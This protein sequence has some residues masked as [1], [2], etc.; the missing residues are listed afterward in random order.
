MRLELRLFVFLGLALVCAQA[1][2]TASNFVW[3]GCGVDHVEVKS[4]YSE[5]PAAL[6]DLAGAALVNY[7]QE[8]ECRLSSGDVVR[9]KFGFDFRALSSS[10]TSWVSIWFN[11]KKWVS[12]RN[13]EVEG[14]NEPRA[15][16]IEVSAE[17]VKLC[18]LQGSIL[19]LDDD[20]DAGNAAPKCTQIPRSHLPH[21]VDVHEPKQLDESEKPLVPPVILAGE[22]HALCRIMARTDPAVREHGISPASH[23]WLN[24]PTGNP[25]RIDHPSALKAKAWME[26]DVA[27]D[28][29]NSGL[30]RHVLYRSQSM[31]YGEDYDIYLTL[32]DADYQRLSKQAV[33]EKALLKIARSAWPVDWLG[34]QD[35]VKAS[36]QLDKLD[37]KLP[38]ADQPES[39]V[40]I[41][42]NHLHIV[43]FA[44]ASRTY[45]LLFDALAG[46][47]AFVVEPHPGG[48][49]E[50]VCVFQAGAVNF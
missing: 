13:V 18:M 30:P 50:P 4:D 47:D 20:D 33:T 1:T 8:S 3:V 35:R 32:D 10:Q 22:H 12:R 34:Q 28:L 48:K 26:S 16:S 7:G 15:A 24:F 40:S 27:V 44:Y 5:A 25:V 17:G 2:A 36:K 45:L 39:E 23:L 14:P 46:G 41:P 6:D 37:L 9:V 11:R 29:D 31:G 19:A 49:L 43:P 38:M 21:S 42:A